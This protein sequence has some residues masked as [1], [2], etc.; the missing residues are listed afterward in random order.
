MRGTNLFEYP[1]NVMCF[2][3]KSDK[4]NKNEIISLPESVVTLVFLFYHAIMRV[5][6]R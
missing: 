2:E 3:K 1:P 4:S 6:K 5:E